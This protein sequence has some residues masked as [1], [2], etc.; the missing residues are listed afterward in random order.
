MI[1]F[2]SK[3]IILVTVL[4]KRKMFDCNKPFLLK[5]KLSEN[6]KGINKCSWSLFKM[7]EVLNKKMK[8]TR[9]FLGCLLSIKFN[10][11]IGIM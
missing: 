6:K 10:T 5:N 8:R 2:T 3:K 7:K 4:E 11:C 1:Y 9:I